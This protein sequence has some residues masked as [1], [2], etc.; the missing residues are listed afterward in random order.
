MAK[1][2]MN[3]RVLEFIAIV[4]PESIFS[5]PTEGH[6][7]TVIAPV[8]CHPVCCRWIQRLYMMPLNFRVLEFIMNAESIFGELRE[9][10]GERP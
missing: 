1:M 7:V 10:S 3:S 4:A 8:T 9:M 2:Y 6:A 5:E